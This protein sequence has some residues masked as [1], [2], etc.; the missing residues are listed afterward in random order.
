MSQKI[1]RIHE[2]QAPIARRFDV[3]MDYGDARQRVRLSSF[4]TRAEAEARIE[5]ANIEDAAY[6]A[7]GRSL[8]KAKARGEG[9]VR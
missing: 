7:S 8:T 4:G 6:E 1:Y 9:E 2:V 3:W 5:R